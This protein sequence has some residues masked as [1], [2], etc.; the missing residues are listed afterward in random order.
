MAM[1]FLSKFVEQFKKPAGCMGRLAGLLMAGEPAK[2]VWTVSLLNLRKDDWALE[3]GFGP[4]RAIESLSRTITEGRIVGID[5]SSVMLRQA[6]KRNKEAIENGVVDLILADVSSPPP[7]KR[8]FDHIL[9]INNI[10]FWEE[11]VD[12]LKKLQKLLKPEGKIAITVQPRMRGADQNTVKEFGQQIKENLQA[13]GY[14]NIHTHIRQMKPVNCV[15][16]TATI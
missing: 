4:G 15:C 1:N 16:V 11:P 6:K 12:S 13:A 10:M 14:R 2:S 7:F 5:I 9:S 3:V 8:K